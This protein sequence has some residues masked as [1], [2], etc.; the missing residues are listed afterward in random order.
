MR[1]SRKLVI[2]I[3]VTV[4]LAVGVL[5]LTARSASTFAQ[6]QEP[7][8]MLD[9][10]PIILKGGSL[11]LEC[12]KKDDCMAF[13]SAIKKHELKDKN[14]KVQRI[15]VRDEYGA[16]LYNGSKVNFPNGKPTIEIYVK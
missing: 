6:L 5:T 2:G 13:N 14:K 9:G 1:L 3:A 10:D 7:L 11:T 15:I 4:I 16:I 8:Q 12:P